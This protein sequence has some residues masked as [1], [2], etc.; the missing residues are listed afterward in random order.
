MGPD[1]RV[2]LRR[3]EAEHDNFRAAPRWSVA[4]PGDGELAGCLAVSLF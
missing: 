2:W 3:L 1:Q 4:T